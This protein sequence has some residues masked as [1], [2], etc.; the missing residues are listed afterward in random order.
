MNSLRQL[1]ATGQSIWLDYIRRDLITSGRLQRLIKEDGVT[2]ITSN[3]T[4]F[5]KALASD[6]E[7]DSAIR[8]ILRSSPD[9][10]SKTLFERIEI[11]DLQM[12]ADVLRPVYDLSEGNDGYVSIEVS[13]HLAYDTKGSI[14]EAKRLWKEVARKNLMIKIPATSQGLPA[15][16]QL[17]AEGINVNITLMFS[18]SQ[19][20]D[21]AEAYLRGIARN[22]RPHE[23]ASVASFFVSRVDTAVDRALEEV[24][25][26]VALALRGKAGITGAR[27]AY[28]RFRQIFL[29]PEFEV[30]KKE[31]GVRLQKPLWAS[32]STKNKAYSDVMYIECLI[33]PYTINSMPPET[34]DAF[35]DHGKVE[36]ALERNQIEAQDVIGHLRT[37]EINPHSIGQELT[38]E[39]VEKFIASYDELIEALSQKRTALA[40][41]EA[42]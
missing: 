31:R 1:T 5:A 20:E 23:V 2:G 17:I 32:T 35:R 10:D 38:D 34:L 18:V 25:T 14:A 15:I 36:V 13:P 37:M 24:G 26:P 22:S 7:Y 30:L 4:I 42:A 3:P 41:T 33:G 16:E 29:S 28:R 40:R 12:A 19:Y 39:G 9:V 6:S 27:L 21:V 8:S 11:Q